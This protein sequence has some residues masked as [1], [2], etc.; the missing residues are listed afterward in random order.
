MAMILRVN[1][2][3]KETIEVFIEEKGKILDSLKGNNQYGSQ[4]LL[5]LIQK[6]LK[7]NKLT[8]KQIQGIE[9]DTGP[10]SFTGLKV[11]VA[12]ANALGFS[13][14]IPVNEKSLETEIKYG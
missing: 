4:I 8:F 1:T 3:D 7:E 5:P 6:I 10:G 12:T 9:V 2:K 13:L 11:G 14:K